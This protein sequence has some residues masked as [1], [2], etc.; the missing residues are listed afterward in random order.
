MDVGRKLVMQFDVVR[1]LADEQV[2]VALEV[3]H[4]VAGADSDP[5]LL[6]GDPVDGGVEKTP[7]AAVPTGL[8]K[9][10]EMQV[11]DGGYQWR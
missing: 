3:L 1:V 10:I 9:W 7:R 5:S 8:E 11:G 6:V 2:L 4:Q